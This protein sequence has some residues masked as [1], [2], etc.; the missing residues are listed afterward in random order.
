RSSAKPFQ[1]LPIVEEG[2]DDRFGISGEELALCCASHAGSAGHVRRVRGL[3][4]RIGLAP[5]DLACGPHRPFDDDA[6]R[7]LDR[8]GEEYAPIHNNC[9]GKHAGMLA[10]AV[11]AGDPTE[12]YL[13]LD[14][15]VQRRFRASLERW[16]DVDPDRLGWATDGCGVPTPYLSLR[17]MARAYGRLARAA[18]R[19]EEAPSAVVSAMIDHPEL[20]S[21]EGR[22]TT[23]LLE[24]GRGTL[25]AKEGA[26]G[27]L[28]L[29]G[30]EE[31]WGMAVKVLDGSKRAMGAAAAE[32]IHRLE[33]LDPAT[34]GRLEEERTRPVRNTRD[35]EVGELRAELSVR[36]GHVAGRV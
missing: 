15:P 26:E 8:A 28:C 34:R 29:A 31:G 35:E 11:H 36:S 24:A 18:A 7:S 23:R 14:H 10:R 33:L 17:Q 2:A 32:L 16:L 25:L 30:L 19:G 21:G 5:G 12:G 1:A 20:V 27:V 6:A 3:L 22:L 4:E 9:S 13:A